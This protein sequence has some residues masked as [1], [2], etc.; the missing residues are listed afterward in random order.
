MKR[1]TL[2]TLLAGMMFI[3]AGLTSCKEEVVDL[4]TLDVTPSTV[5]S[6]NGSNNQ[7]E[8]LTVTTTATEWSFETSADWIIADKSAD[9]LIVNVQDNPGEFR[10]GTITFTAGD[11]PK[12]TIGVGQSKVGEVVNPDQVEVSMFN[13]DTTHGATATI[14][15]DSPVSHVMYLQIPSAIAT[16]VEAEIVIDYEY[17]VEY[18]IL[19][20]MECELFPAEL[21]TISGDGVAKIAKDKRT[22]GDITVDMVFDETKLAFGVDYLLPLQVNVTS[23]NGVAAS[24]VAGRV[25]YV[26]RRAMNKLVRNIGWPEVNNVNPLNALEYKLDTGEYFY[27]A[28]VMFSSNLV[29]DADADV[30]K[31]IHNPNNQQ[32][33]D[34]ADLY[35][36]PLQKVGIKVYLSVLP[37]H[38]PAGITTLSERGA[39][40]LAEDI[41]NIVYDYD[42]DGVAFDEE[43]V[44]GSSSST[45]FD[46]SRGIAQAARLFYK[47]K[48]KMRELCGEN[49][50]II[51]FIYS[52]LTPNI[53]DVEG[54]K[55]VE[56]VD[57][58][59]GNYGSGVE[60]NSATGMTRANC[61]YM[62]VECG[63]GYGSSGVQAGINA[64][65]GGYGWFMWFNHNPN[66]EHSGSNWLASWPKL[67]ETAKGL[68]P[69]SSLVTPT[70]YYTKGAE[71]VISPERKEYTQA[72]MDQ[73]PMVEPLPVE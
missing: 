50:D 70:G 33:L 64:R 22:S 43:Y 30:V 66:P 58:M 36:K 3:S 28:I 63:L 17:L 53:P 8:T 5:L 29:F 35:I 55:A 2:L 27:D 44:S 9:K 61:S 52:Y 42:L 21:V 49:K 71:G 67:R 41:A 69:G 57:I 23:D 12:V 10:H 24:G 6:F 20:G 18:N 15:A 31:I 32:L 73:M 54:H 13:G 40:M 72:Q 7:N 59:N 4:A 1:K 14:G 68:Y 26:V 60:P 38:T 65:E 46:S 25:N 37:H 11:A 16:D 19:N 48:T 45:L 62:S 39:E 56:F 47:T 34:D 51:L